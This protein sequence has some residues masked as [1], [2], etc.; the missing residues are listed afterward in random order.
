[1][2]RHSSGGSPGMTMTPPGTRFGATEMRR[3]VLLFILSAVFAVSIGIGYDAA[4]FRPMGRAV[5]NAAYLF[6][7]H[8][9][10][11]PFTAA[12]FALILA[13]RMRRVACSIDRENQR[14]VRMDF[15]ARF[16]RWLTALPGMIQIRAVHG[17]QWLTTLSDANQRAGEDRC[18]KC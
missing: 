7:N 16:G 4:G 10:W 1:M 17:M 11:L 15:A 5:G 3:R 8:L 2:N 14:A 9:P 12:F 18:P 6:S 13:S